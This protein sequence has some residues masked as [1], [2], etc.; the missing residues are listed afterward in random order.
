MTGQPGPDESVEIQTYDPGR[1]VL[2][3][4]VESPGYLFFSENY[5]PYWK[6]SVDGKPAPLLRCDVAMRAIPVEPGEHVV[7]MKYFSKWYAAG[8]VAFILT[9]LVVAASVAFEVR[10]RAGKGGEGA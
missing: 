7:E 10:K 8:A 4:K 3:A 6:A 5:L 1:V 9:C 2:K